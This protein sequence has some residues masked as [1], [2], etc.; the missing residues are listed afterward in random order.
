MK[1][2]LLSLC[3]ALTFLTANAQ[4]KTPQPSPLSKIEQKVGLVDVSLEYSRPGV[5]GRKIFGDLVPFGKLWRTGAN[6]NTI[7]TLSD[8]VMI[9]GKELQKGSYAI[10]TTPNKTEWEVVFYTDTENWGTP[11]KWSDD[12]VAL[13]TTVKTEKIP[14]PIET[15]T[16]TIDNLKTDG[17]TLGMLWENTYAGIPFTVATDKAVL[18]NIEQV[19][20]G[21]SAN[22]Y[23]ASASYYLETEKDINK[24]K[25]WIDKAVELTKDKPRFWYLRKQALIY[26]KAGDTKGAIKAAKAS[27]E[28]AEKAGNEQYVKQNKES[29]KQWGA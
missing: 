1:K 9:D 6:K 3:I 13:K 28:H 11:Q 8:N 18:A 15:F 27:L 19:M 16:I 22:D 17:A 29:L 23:Y 24:A 20:S 21:P 7:I 26:E 12:K 14:M 5:K 2:T 4:V 25:M 10:F